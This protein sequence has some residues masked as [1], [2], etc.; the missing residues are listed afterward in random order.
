MKYKDRMIHNMAKVFTLVHQLYLC[1]F[2]AE[3]LVETDFLQCFP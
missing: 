3:L 2:A 1:L